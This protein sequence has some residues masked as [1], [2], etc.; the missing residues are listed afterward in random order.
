[1]F[2]KVLLYVSLFALL[3]GACTPAIEK[4]AVQA[5]P[6]A[7]PEP[8]QVPQATQPEPT[9]A[10]ALPPTKASV[11]TETPASDIVEI[12]FAKNFTLEYRDGYKLLTVHIASD[13][14]AQEVSYLLVPKSVEVLPDAGQATIIRTPVES[15]VSMSSTYL[16]FLEQIG[17]LESVVAVDD[18]TYIY[19]KTIRLWA[20][21]GIIETVGGTMGGDEDIEKLI[22]LNPDIVMTSASSTALGSNPKL[23]ETGIKVVENADYLEQSPLGR[24]EWGL[25]VAAFFDLEKVAAD[26]FNKVVQE[27]EEVKALTQNLEKKVTVF[28]NTDYQGTWYMPGADSYPAQLL[29]DAGAEFVFADHP[30]STVPL[31]FEAVFE[32]A[33]EADFWINVGFTGDLQSLLAMDSRYSEF[34][35]FK[36]GNVYNFNARANENGG[37]D[38]YESGVANPHLVLKDLVKI[39]YPDLLPEH[40]LYYYQQLH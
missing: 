25:F 36:D 27:Y 33:K 19:N 40:E 22:E 12:R 34:K 4:T 26:H 21:E 2:K 10:A 9:Q 8:T 23:K 11:E 14:A 5:P 24:A 17:K 37:L 32:Q 39:F 20:A 31:S 18:P 35:A 28:N 16:P 13:P 3:L 30:G 1:M 29:Q 38:Y 15:F 6:I 7:Q